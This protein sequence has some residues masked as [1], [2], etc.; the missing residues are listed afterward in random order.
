MHPILKNQLIAITATT[1]AGL[2]M[3]A[4]LKTVPTVE[5]PNWASAGKSEICFANTCKPRVN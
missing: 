1:A 5:Q 3:L 2:F 4:A